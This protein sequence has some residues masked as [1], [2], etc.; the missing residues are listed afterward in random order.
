M[1]LEIKDQEIIDEFEFFEDWM[2][3]YNYIIDL[4]KNLEPLAENLRIEENL[5]SG[6]TSKVWVTSEYKD[7]KM[8]FKADSDA[9][10]PKGIVALILKLFNGEK[11]EDILKY[12][13][14]FISKI[15]LQQ[16]LSPNRANGLASMID[17]IK[18][19]SAKNIK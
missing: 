13:P 2:E 10:I 1:S 14:E 11:P 19:L 3:K 7:D 17:R 5:I 12:N 16:H 6:C 4:G 15:G 18:L 9:L 8:E